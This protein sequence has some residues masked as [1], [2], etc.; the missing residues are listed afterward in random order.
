M[1]LFIHTQHLHI[2]SHVIWN[3]NTTFMLYVTVITQHK[4]TIEVVHD[5]ILLP[6]TTHI[7]PL[8]HTK[9]DSNTLRPLQDPGPS[10]VWHL[11]QVGRGSDAQHDPLPEDAH[12]DQ[13]ARPLFPS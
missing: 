2:Y 13:A 8:F 4:T 10:R 9:R 11:R 6:L 5:S 1:P 12:E 3:Y 7:A